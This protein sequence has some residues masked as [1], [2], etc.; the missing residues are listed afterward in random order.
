MSNKIYY[1][2]YK[3]CRRVYLIS[4]DIQNWKDKKAFPRPDVRSAPLPRTNNPVS[5]PP[6]LP[7]GVRKRRGSG[8]CADSRALTVGE[9]GGTI[10]LSNFRSIYIYIYIHKNICTVQPKFSPKKTQGLHMRLLKNI[11]TY[12]HKYCQLMLF[13][14]PLNG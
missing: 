14:Q 12:I 8:G 11:S 6:A 13:T 3:K 9:P 10:Q 4:K 7:E 2:K 1:H 5:R